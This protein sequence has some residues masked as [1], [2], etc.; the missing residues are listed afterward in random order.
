MLVSSPAKAF[1]DSVR[2]TYCSH[3]QKALNG[4]SNRAP[5][6]HSDAS[7]EGAA[8]VREL[9]R[10]GSHSGQ[11]SRRASNSSEFE[12]V[13]CNVLSNE[14]QVKEFTELCVTRFR[15]FCFD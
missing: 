8:T 12:A 5:S 14:T 4:S 2:K 7:L 13:T 3:C 11:S 1:A 6:E 9:S 15:N 10:N